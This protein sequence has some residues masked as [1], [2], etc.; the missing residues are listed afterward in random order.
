MRKRVIRSLVFGALAVMVISFLV[1]TPIFFFSFQADAVDGIYAEIRDSISHIKPIAKMSL[2]FRTNKMDRLF[3]ESMNQISYFSK[4]NILFVDETGD[5]IWAN[6]IPK[7]I[8]SEI[9]K[10]EASKA[11]FA[12]DGREQLCTKNLLNEL[13]G[14]KTI[15]IGE[16]VGSDIGTDFWYV[17]CSKTAPNFTRQYKLAFLEILSIEIVTLCFV[18]VFMYLFSG[19]ITRPLKKINNTLKEF[20]KGNFDRRVE[21]KHDNEIGEL[22]SNINKMADSVGALEKMRQDFV[23]D[24]SHELRT[25]LTSISGF[26]G[27]I[28]DGTIPREEH[29]KYL[30][31][32]LSESRRLSKLLNELLNLSRIEDS[33]KKLE[34]SDFDIEEMSKIVLLKFEKEITDKNIEV[35]FELEGEDFIIHAD[36]DKFT[37]VLINLMHN[38]VKFTPDGG[39]IS[40]SIKKSGGKCIFNITNSGNGIPED[41]LNF[42]WERFYKADNSRSTDRSGIGIGLYIVKKIIDAHDEKITVESIAGEST[43]FEFTAELA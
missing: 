29:E 3:N 24:I 38:S 17:F 23:S 6:G 21:Y 31:I 8:D 2:S 15:T 27:G 18:A 11:V 30:G 19:N 10:A 22:A 34:F 36:R 42:I 20:A 28:I 32:V 5:I 9:L 4:A 1:L 12:M 37:Q 26:I 7:H 14:E 40:I 25:P 43:S 39:Q 35:S 13:Y 41:K 16:R 33:V